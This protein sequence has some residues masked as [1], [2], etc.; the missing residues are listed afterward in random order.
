MWGWTIFLLGGM[1]LID[2][3]DVKS[4]NFLEIFNFLSISDKIEIFETHIFL[5]DNSST[6]NEFS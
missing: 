3:I 5:K 2:V 4:I 1:G 6:R